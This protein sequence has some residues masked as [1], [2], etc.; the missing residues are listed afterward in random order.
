MRLQAHH[1]LRR[2]LRMCARTDRQIHIGRRY[3]Q[4]LK[5]DIRHIDVI[6][7]T[8]MD[9]GLSYIRVLLQGVQDWSDLHEVRARSYNMKYVHRFSNYQP[10]NLRM[11]ELPSKLGSVQDP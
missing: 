9:E 6:V 11:R 7:L 3:L 5:E 8:G 2:L 4:L 1:D 10:I